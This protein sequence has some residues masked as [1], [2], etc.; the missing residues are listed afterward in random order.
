MSDNDINYKRQG[1]I[2][3]GVADVTYSS[4]SHKSAKLCDGNQKQKASDDIEHGIYTEDYTYPE[5]ETQTPDRTPL[6]SSIPSPDKPTI[7]V[8]QKLGD[9]DVKRQRQPSPVL[10]S[11]SDDSDDEEVCDFTPPI[12][13]RSTAVHVHEVKVEISE[14]SSFAAENEGYVPEEESLLTRRLPPPI[15][16][17]HDDCNNTVRTRRLPPPVPEAQNDCIENVPRRRSPHPIPEEYDDYNGISNGDGSQSSSDEHG[18]MSSASYTSYSGNP[19]EVLASIPQTTGIRQEKQYSDH[20]N[21]MPNA[22][23]SWKEPL[24]AVK[25]I[26][27]DNEETFVMETDTKEDEN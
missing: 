9:T 16:T 13:A 18:P 27:A 17:E 4:S 15:P 11:E 25:T 1:S 26:V 10:E 12:P 24:T 19:N 5:E 3:E 8:R 20:Y 2:T 23:D 14:T 6:Q 7:N 21:S 22:M